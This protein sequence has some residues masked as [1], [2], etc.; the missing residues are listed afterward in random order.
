MKRLN[1]DFKLHIGLRNLKTALAATIVALFYLLIGRDP[2]FACIGAIFGTG[3]DMKNSRLHGGNRFFGTIFG[4]VLGM[5]LFRI[6]IIFHSEGLYPDYQFHWLMLVL[7]FV[8]VIVL[9]LVSQFFRWAG[10]IQPGGVMLCIILFRTPV[11]TYI[12]Y[13]INRIVDTGIGVLAA[14]LLNYL[15][16]R[17]RVVAW[18]GKLGFKRHKDEHLANQGK[19]E[20]KV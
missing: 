10:A 9:I 19:K 15:L 6:Y 7:L 13:S 17:E 1:P 3:Y 16:P 2:T 14:L 5:I 11:E 12:S 8:G 4:G 20:D 18:T